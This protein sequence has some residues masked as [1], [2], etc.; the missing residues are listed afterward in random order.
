MHTIHTHAHTHAF[1][2]APLLRPPFLRPTLYFQKKGG[3]WGR[4]NEDSR[5]RLAVKPPPL[6]RIRVEINEALLCSRRRELLRS[7][8]RGSILKDG[9]VVGHV[10]VAIFCKNSIAARLLQ[11]AARLHGRMTCRIAGLREP[12]EISEKGQDQISNYFLRA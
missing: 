2:T 12:S 8:C 6:P 4:N 9:R 7:T 11:P 1:R 3:G 10:H 5:F